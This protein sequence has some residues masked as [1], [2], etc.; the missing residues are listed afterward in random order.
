LI[1]TVKQALYS[2]SY[3]TFIVGEIKK[4]K[5]TKKQINGYIDLI[6]PFTLLAPIIVSTCI[7]FASFF[8]NGRTYDLFTIWWSTILPASFTFFI[9]NAASNALNQVTDVNADKISKPY[10]PLVKGDISFKEAKA[11][12]FILYIMAFL[13]SLL[14]NLMFSLFIL[15]II[16]FTV[17]YSITP[18]IKNI[19]FLNQLWVGVPRGFLGILGSWSVFGNA[20]EPLPLTIGAIAMCFLIGGS[21]T[22]DIIDIEADKKNGA[23]TLVNTFGVKKAALMALPFMVL[24]F[25]YI[26]ILIDSGILNSYLWLLTFLAIPGYLIFHKMVKYKKKAGFSEN[27]SSWTLMYVTYFVFAFGFS[28][29][30]ILGSVVL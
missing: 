2:N 9:L 28:I 26:P 29:L 14:I 22:K 27:T 17:T 24:P 23:Q 8:Y 3:K 20:I 11:V 21:I 18:R 19:L 15:L 10:R 4:M 1:T 7:M 6:R 12:S 16:A 13:L 25:A 5:I 30:T